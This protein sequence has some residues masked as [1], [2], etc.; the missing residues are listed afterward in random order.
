M[1]KGPRAM[2]KY[3][4][5]G[6]ATLSEGVVDCTG[7]ELQV[8]GREHPNIVDLAGIIGKIL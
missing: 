6:G 4:D 7:S 8:G 2:H 3:L 1:P 5:T